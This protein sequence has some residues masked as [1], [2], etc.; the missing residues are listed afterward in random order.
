MKKERNW[1]PCRQCGNNHSNPASSSLCSDCGSSISKERVDKQYNR[2]LRDSLDE[3]KKELLY[4][5]IDYYIENGCS[6]I[7]EEST[8]YGI[9]VDLDT[10]DDIS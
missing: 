8:L 7:S 9:I 10:L 3:S 4:R 5:A 2:S 6:S 1:K